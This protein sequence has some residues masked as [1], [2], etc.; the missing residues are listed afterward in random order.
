[1][2]D[3]VWGDVTS[4]LDGDTFVI[5]VTHVGKLNSFS[6][7]DYETIRIA[8]TDAPELPSRGGVLAKQRLERK[9]RGRHVKCVIQSRDKFGRLVCAVY[10]AERQMV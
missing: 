4:V 10:Y 3:V 7:N 1:M 2:A 6:Y 8:G 5:Y 9:L